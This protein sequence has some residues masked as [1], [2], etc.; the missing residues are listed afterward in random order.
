MEL[1]EL[2]KNWN[3]MEERLGKL[4]MENRQ[5]LNKTVNGKVKQMR[6]RL[7]LRL[8]FVVFLLPLF[9]AFITHHAEYDFST[10]T[11]ALMYLFV[12]VV[13]VRQFAW[14]WLL[15]KMDCLK[16]SV[17]EVCLAESRF[18]IAF[19]V[20]IT[21]SVLCGI[22]LLASMIWD[23]SASGERYILIGAWM[24]LCVGL[25]FGLRAFLKAWRGVKELREAIAELQ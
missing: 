2:K 22:P 18:R 6:Q 23:M 5:M 25:L 7:M 4:E 24:G 11:W 16:M 10:L 14:M 8:T 17:R 21:A 19:K 9:L 20:G 3:V 13:A 1:D 15:N 12:A